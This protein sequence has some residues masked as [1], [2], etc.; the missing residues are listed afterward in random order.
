[1]EDTSNKKNEVLEYENRLN[2]VPFKTFK[3]VDF[4]VF[5]SI[6][7][8]AKK[9]IDSGDMEKDDNGNP[10]IRIDYSDIKQIAGFKKNHITN[11]EFN[12]QFLKGLTK[13][14]LTING[15]IKKGNLESDL[16]LFPQFDRDTAN[17]QLIIHMADDFQELLYEFDEI[18]FTKLELKK[19]IRLE[20]K[21]TKTLYRKLSQFRSSGKYVVKQDTFRELFDVPESYNQSDIMKRIINPSVKAL[22]EEFENLKCETHKAPKRGAPVDR[23]K[24]TFVATPKRNQQTEGQLDMEQVTEEMQKYKKQ[25]E[26]SKNSFNNFQQNTYDVDKLEKQLL[27]N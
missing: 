23:Y 2:D 11:K 10:I 6:L 16:V 21:Y 20:S 17:A 22:S 26:K 18:G 3:E 13:K 7:L 19:F 5:F 24:F 4:N 14:L 8:L 15:T 9:G 1:M 27:D 25:K 12:E